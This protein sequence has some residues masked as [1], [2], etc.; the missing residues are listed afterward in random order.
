MPPLYC[1]AESNVFFKYKK[2]EWFESINIDQLKRE[3]DTRTVEF[4]K[5]AHDRSRLAEKE[6]L[7]MGK[8]EAR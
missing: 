4:L 1:Y 8:I 2:N 6:D 7:L 5:Q 3:Q